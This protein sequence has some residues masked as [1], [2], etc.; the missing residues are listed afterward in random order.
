ML[1]GEKLKVSIIFWWN[2]H[3][4]IVS[5]YY[6]IKLS[7]INTTTFNINKTNCNNSLLFQWHLSLLS[8]Y[9]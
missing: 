8:I 5:L 6:P 7:T 3:N 2:L 9:N 1:K 4:T